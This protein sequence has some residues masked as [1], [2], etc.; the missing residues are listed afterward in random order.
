MPIINLANKKKRDA[1]VSIEPVKPKREIKYIDQDGNVVEKVRVIKSSLA[2]QI[3]ALIEEADSLGDLGWLLADTDLEIDLATFG[4]ILNETNRVYF[5]ENG[6]VAHVE[7]MEIV[8]APDGTEK[9]RKSRDIRTQNVNTD[10][11]VPW[12]N[13]LM[14]K[15]D[16]VRRFVFSSTKQI[17]HVN[18]LTFDFLFEIAKELHEKESLMIVGGGPKGN[19]PL[20]FQRRGKGYRGFLEGRIKDE[21]YMLLLHLTNL[22]LKSPE[23]VEEEEA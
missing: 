20:I 16:A 9:E 2:H 13:K 5:S 15:T 4:K 21:S 1:Q 17:R 19:E 12:T 11:P 6:I 14:K 7:E 10:V 8:F 3:D 18:G 23:P 22:E